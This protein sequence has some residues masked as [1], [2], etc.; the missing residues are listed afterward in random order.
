[1]AND[2]CVASEEVPRIKLHG[3]YDPC[4]SRALFRH[5]AF[6]IGLRATESY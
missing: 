6:P 2:E 3:K 5:P 1:M 4:A